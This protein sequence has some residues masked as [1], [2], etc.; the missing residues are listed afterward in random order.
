MA[1]MKERK[2]L[3]IVSTQFYSISEGCI[4]EMKPHHVLALQ[5]RAAACHATIISPD[6]VYAVAKVVIPRHVAS[7]PEFDINYFS[8]NNIPYEFEQI[9]SEV[10]C[11]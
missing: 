8:S 5:A 7:D 9:S 10:S 6:T 4:V 3:R 2:K 11:S 1:N